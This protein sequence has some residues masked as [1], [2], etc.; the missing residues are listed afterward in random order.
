MA[1]A[2][3]LAIRDGENVMKNNDGDLAASFVLSN[4][5][6]VSFFLFF[7]RIPESAAQ[8]IA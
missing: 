1:S 6:L 7:E 5:L 3:P 2:L 8:K 4:K